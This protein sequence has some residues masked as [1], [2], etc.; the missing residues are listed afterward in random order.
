MHYFSISH[1]LINLQK[2]NENFFFFKCCSRCYIFS[3]SPSI[4][5]VLDVSYFTNFLAH[6]KSNFTSQLSKA[7]SI[8]LQKLFKY[9][10]KAITYTFNLLL[11]A[12]VLPMTF[13]LYSN[14]LLV[15]ALLLFIL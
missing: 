12:G 13:V 2:T 3:F 4:A 1:Y 5:A 8:D 15:S 6:L 10:N 9:F 7:K 14:H 11:S